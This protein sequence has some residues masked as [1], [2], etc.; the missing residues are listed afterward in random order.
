MIEF[1]MKPTRPGEKLH[2]HKGF[3]SIG[4]DCCIGITQT[5]F[6]EIN[7]ASQGKSCNSELSQDLFNPYEG[8]GQDL[9]RFLLRYWFVR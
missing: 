8:I 7:Q 3:R 4:T 5:S 2:C 1:G 6:Q 9:G